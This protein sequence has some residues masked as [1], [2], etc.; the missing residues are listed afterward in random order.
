MHRLSFTL[1]GL[2]V[3]PLLSA[4]DAPHPSVKIAVY[5]GVGTSAS[6]ENVLAVLK[7]V[8]GVTVRTL[9]A[10]DIT[11]GRLK[12]YR[13]VVFPGGTSSGQAQA[14][15]TAGRE[16]VKAFVKQ[17]GGYVGIC[18]GAYLASC[19]YDWSLH[20]LDATVVDRQHWARGFGDVDL[21]LTPQGK[22]LLAV[23]T[24]TLGIY[25]HQGPL[26][27]PGNNPAVPDFTPLASFET[28]I[29][30]NGA[31]K[32]VMKGTT[33]VA[34]GV[35]GAGRVVCFSPHPEKKDQT[36]A[37]LHKAVDWVVGK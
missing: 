12:G 20:V 1:L 9:S 30:K 14:L 8:P 22:E 4:S 18:A 6:K 5:T 15:G 29:A 31:P 19:S 24:D 34:V 35:F 23:P 37:L 10:D 33:A 13:V 27:A 16:Q 21:R 32:G 25:Y 2:I 36:R 3:A 26:L 17:G 28:E 7:E 11:A